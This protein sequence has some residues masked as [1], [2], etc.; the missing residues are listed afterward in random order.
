MTEITQGTAVAL[1]SN[2][3][4]MMG[5]VRRPPRHGKASVYWVRRLRASSVR[6]ESLTVIE[7]RELQAFLEQQDRL[8]QE[9]WAFIS[10]D[11]DL[12]S[13]RITPPAEQPQHVKD[14]IRTGH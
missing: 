2:R 6:L 4:T 1:V 5:R 9:A 13:Y 14:F 3:E 8:H 11:E 12:S 10:G 7:D